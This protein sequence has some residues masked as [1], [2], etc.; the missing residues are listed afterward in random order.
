[1]ALAEALR[2]SRERSGL[3][4][5]THLDRLAL[6]RAVLPLLQRASSLRRVLVTHDDPDRALV[7]ADRANVHAP[8]S[9]C[10][11]ERG[12]LTGTVRELD[13]E[14]GGH[15]VLPNAVAVDASRLVHL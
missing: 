14:F 12:E 10:G 8:I 11:R 9:E 4:G 13:H 1:L 6:R 7:R 3:V 15:D 5:Q 2:E